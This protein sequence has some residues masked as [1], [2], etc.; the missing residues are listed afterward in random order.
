VAETELA[1]AEAALAGGQPSVALENA[2]AA[3]KWAAGVGNTETEWRCWWLAARTAQA[4][5]RKSDAHDF[6]QRASKLLAGLAQKWDPEDLR[7]YSTRPDVAFA[8]GQ[9][10]GLEEH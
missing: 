10:A 3:Q 2:Q 9:L 6:A 1:Q 8:K 4:S 5:G 7:I